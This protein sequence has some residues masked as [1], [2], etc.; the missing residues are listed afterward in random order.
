[1]KLPQLPNK[2]KIIKKAITL[3]IIC[4]TLLSSTLVLTSCSKKYT[5]EEARA[6]LSEVLEKEV[7]LCKVIYGEGLKTR[8][9]PSDHLDDSTFYYMEVAPDSEYVGLSQLEEAVRDVYAVEIRKVVWEYAFGNGG[10]EKTLI[11]RYAEN[12]GYLQ[13]DVTNEGFNLKSVA[14]IGESTVRRAKKDMIEIEI[15]VSSDGGETFRDKTLILKNEDGVWK[16]DT[17]SWCVDVVW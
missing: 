13:I 6:I 7:K 17:Q 2:M 1:M 12:N 8:E 9:D 15:K 11:P 4:C 10:E 3:L 16:L 14:Y 5:D